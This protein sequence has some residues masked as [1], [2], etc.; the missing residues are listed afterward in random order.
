MNKSS[1]PK[2]AKKPKASETL[3]LAG[4]I[5]TLFASG[6]GFVAVERRTDEKGQSYPF[7]LDIVNAYD[8]SEP[9][10]FGIKPGAKVVL[11]VLKGEVKDVK[12][13]K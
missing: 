3:E 10:K 8:G 1:K 11:Q 4:K 7:T 5:T 2:A 6:L 13:V 9:R 12:L